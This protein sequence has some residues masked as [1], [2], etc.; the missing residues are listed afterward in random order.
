MTPT[1]C[2]AAPA[3]ATTSLFTS[4]SPPEAFATGISI[5]F[6]STGCFTKTASATVYFHGRVE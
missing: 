5:A 3:N 2:I 4:A 6:S 1:D